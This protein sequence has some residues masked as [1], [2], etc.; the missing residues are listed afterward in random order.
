M[1]L[2]T[3]ARQGCN[4]F[5]GCS[6]IL[7]G[8]M[9]LAVSIFFLSMMTLLGFAIG[10]VTVMIIRWIF[11]PQPRPYNAP[12]ISRFES[13]YEQ[14]LFKLEEM[15]GKDYSTLPLNILSGSLILS[16]TP[17]L[18][19]GLLIGSD[20]MILPVIG[21]GLAFLSTMLLSQPYNWFNRLFLSLPADDAGLIDSP[22]EAILH[23]EDD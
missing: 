20:A 23:D 21:L 18:V 8:G 19:L 6:T 13:T 3:Y 1:G 7:A 4:P 11:A 10:Y 15:T 14:G 16:L 9:I 22:D 12:P 17:C 5:T 2:I